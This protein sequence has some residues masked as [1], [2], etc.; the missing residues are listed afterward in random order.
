[1]Y[2]A[3]EEEQPVQSVASKMKSGRRMDSAVSASSDEAKCSD[4]CRNVMS[5][6]DQEITR[7]MLQ[8]QIQNYKS[9]QLA[10]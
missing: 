10:I 6:D 5:A 9:V 4:S 2:N 8:T 1:M 3:V 7:Q